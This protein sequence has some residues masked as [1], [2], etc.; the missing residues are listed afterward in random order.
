MCSFSF[1][2]KLET[3]IQ[4][5]INSYYKHVKGKGAFETLNASLM[6][7]DIYDSAYA[8]VELHTTHSSLT[9]L[10]TIY[11]DM[12]DKCDGDLSKK[13]VSVVFAETEPG[14]IFRSF[15]QARDSFEESDDNFGEHCLRVLSCE[16]HDSLKKANK[17]L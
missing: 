3:D 11:E 4:N 13:D 16:L 2:Q 5:T 6:H 1:A 7:G 10:E 8:Q 9:A 14:K 15:L 17:K 12:V